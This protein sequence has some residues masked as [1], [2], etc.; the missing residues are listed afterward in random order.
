[1]DTNIIQ[2][3]VRGAAVGQLKVTDKNLTDEFTYTVT[4]E[5]GWMFDVTPE[6]VLQ[7]A[8]IVYAD[9]EAKSVLNITVTVTDKLG[10]SFSKDFTWAPRT[11]AD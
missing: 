11:N 5:D 6:G 10:K 2:E 9:F 3:S 8:G 4:G 1:M 7:L